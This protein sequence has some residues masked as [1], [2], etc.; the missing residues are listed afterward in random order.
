MCSK[1]CVMIHVTKLVSRVSSHVTQTE[2]VTY[3]SFL[4]RIY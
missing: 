3:S 2:Y 1:V 4:G